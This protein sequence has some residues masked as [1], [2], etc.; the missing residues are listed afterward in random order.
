MYGELYCIQ[1]KFRQVSANSAVFSVGSTV[2]EFVDHYVIS[3]NVEL[4]E[5]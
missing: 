5:G 3:V 1:H 4:G 2:R